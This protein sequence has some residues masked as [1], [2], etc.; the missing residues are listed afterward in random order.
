[1]RDYLTQYVSSAQ[2][3]SLIEETKSLKDDLAAVRY[4]VLI[5][6][7]SFQVRNFE[8][9]PDYSAEVQETFRKFQQGAEG[10][11]LQT[12]YGRDLYERVFADRIPAEAR[13]LAEPVPT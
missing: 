6:D 4:C 1:L 3:C 7:G 8:S 5:N 10:E 11:P 13:A 9:E 2:F 12:S